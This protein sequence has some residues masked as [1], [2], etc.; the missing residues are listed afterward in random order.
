MPDSQ[1]EA[2]SWRAVRGVSNAA[3]DML[4]STAIMAGLVT[5][6]QLRDQALEGLSRLSSEVRNDPQG[7]FDRTVSA[8]DRYLTQTEGAQIAEDGLRLLTSTLA[9]GVALRATTDAASSAVRAGAFYCRNSVYV[10]PAVPY[11]TLGGGIFI[12]SLGKRITTVTK[13]MSDRFQGKDYLNP[14]TNRPLAPAPGEVL[15]VDHIFAVSAIIEM[16]G[17]DILTKSQMIDIIQDRVGLGNLQALPQR[18]NASKGA[19]IKWSKYRDRDLDP[20]YRS[21]LIMKQELLQMKIAEQIRIFRNL[22]AQG[23]SR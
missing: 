22:N 5:D 4:D 17:F 21:E 15:A 18:L 12:P 20:Q 14:F 11:G 8:A 10:P 1:A 13:A 19:S 9:G 16:R 6:A 7:V 3:L 2:L 23:G